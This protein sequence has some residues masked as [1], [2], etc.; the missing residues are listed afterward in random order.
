M[1]QVN[2]DCYGNPGSLSGSVTGGTTPYKYEVNSGKTYLSGP[3]VYGPSTNPLYSP[4]APGY[5]SYSVTDAAGCL[6]TA[7][8]LSVNPLTKTPMLMGAVTAPATTQVCYGSSKTITTI[9]IGGATPYT[10]SLSTNGVSGM[11]V[12]SGSRYFNQLA[13]TYFITVKDNVG[14]TYNTDTI[15]IVQ[16][17]AKVSFASSTSGAACNTEGNILVTAAGGY[18]GYS[19]SDNGGGSYQGSDMFSGLGYGSY[20]V[21]VKDQNGCA[22]SS[23]TV[24]LAAL[25]S[26]AITAGNNPVCPGGSTTISITPSGGISPYTYSLDGLAY[27]GS[28]KRY[29]NVAA[30]MH[31]ITVMD[32]VGCTYSPA[33]INI[34]TMSCPGPLTEGGVM[35]KTAGTEQLFAAHV[36]PNPAQSAFHL[37]MESSSREDVELVVT[38]ML[39]VK[40]Y[41]GKGGIDGTYEFGAGFTSGMYILQIRQGN[42]VHT[43]KLVKGN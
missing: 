40:V 32:N 12:P 30:G 28:S 27:V 31:T 26:S 19:Y 39:G 18:G 29:F 15:S 20:I 34:T 16:P 17:A 7:S 41:E 1:T 25:S 35:Q 6:D 14:C 42:T 43:V 37:Q 2:P 24:K 23:A 36:S 22:A 21:A 11:F 38:N 10:Y 4:V 9:P 13:G 5:Y 33:A 8:R 3:I